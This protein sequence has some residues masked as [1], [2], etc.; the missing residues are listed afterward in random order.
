MEINTVPVYK[1]SHKQLT[2]SILEFENLSL[3]NKRNAV[4]RIREI[5]NT[6]VQ[7]DLCTVPACTGCQVLEP[8]TG[9]MEMLYGS[10]YSSPVCQQQ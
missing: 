4:Y 8:N 10:L 7:C 3:Q 9:F 1:A 6:R 5:H 2:E